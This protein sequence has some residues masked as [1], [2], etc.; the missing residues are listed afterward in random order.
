MWGNDVYPWMNDVFRMLSEWN[1]IS[2]Q[3]K[4]FNEFLN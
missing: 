2:I 3:N 4:N 1:M